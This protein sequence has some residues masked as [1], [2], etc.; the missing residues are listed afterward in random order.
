[1]VAASQL[2]ARTGAE[3]LAKG[4]NAADALVA[5]AFTLAVTEPFS[6]G[7]GGGGFALLYDAKTHEVH[8]VDFRETAPAAASPA[9]FNRK[10]MYDP[11][12]SRFGGRAVATPGAVAGYA[13][14][15]AN[16]G[17]RPL[18]ELVAGAADIAEQGFML[19]PGWER[20][21]K[22]GARALSRFWN[23]ANYYGFG[24]N[25]LWTVR[26]QPALATLLRA[27][28]EKGPEAFY[29]GAAA[30][31]VVRATSQTHGVLA[32]DDLKSYAARPLTPLE[33]S[34][35][36]H[37]VVTVPPPSAG[38]VALL[39]TL[40]GL[41]K[42][43]PPSGR[44]HT[45]DATRFH[46]LVELWDRAYAAR[47]NFVGDPRADSAVSTA[48][49]R[50]LDK[51]TIDTWVASIGPRATPA[52]Q[53]GTMVDRIAEGADTTHLCTVDAAGNVA[54]MTTTINGPFGSGVFVPELGIILNNEMDDF[55]AATGPNLY[56]LVGGKYNA[57]APGKTPVSTM[58]PT[59]VFDGDRPWIALG[60]PGG[61][62]IA[63]TISQV[64]VHLM[65]DRLDLPQALA[66]PRLHAQFHPDHV[67][68]EPK[69]F[70]AATLAA[71]EAKGHRIAKSPLMLG[72]VQAITIG[73]DGLRTG[74][75]DLRGFGA[76]VAEDE[77]V[78]PEKPAKTL[79]PARAPPKK[80]AARQ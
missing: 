55:A 62:T 22:R 50:L 77:P 46:D 60:T 20:G 43:N 67:L 10:G 4:G 36:G 59:I 26:R 56:G 17:T 64:L 70:S 58:T 29:T 15:A 13:Y 34:Y 12:L 45:V 33:G 57:V 78:A 37:R 79:V 51:H 71:L 8:A 53:V 65:D 38:G 3:V 19:T 5:T 2:A 32:L 61:S 41:E 31:A 35:R 16:F 66:V 21:V 63:T 73:P 68:I 18:R 80:S 69:G 28:G 75:S 76:A 40:A 54:L 14:V 39:E 44:E 49:S 72:N 6:S 27:I 52:A 9:M 48:V 11:D 7:L 23:A 74:A 42:L 47:T 25:I 24:R 1:V 30:E